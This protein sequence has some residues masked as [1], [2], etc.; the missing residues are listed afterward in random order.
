MET[1]RDKL[2]RLGIERFWA[3]D[4]NADGTR[5][6]AYY[7]D[8]EGDGLAVIWPTDSHEGKRAKDRSSAM[9]YTTRRT[10]PAY[11]FGHYGGG[12]YSRTYELQ[13]DLG[14]WLGRKVRVEMLRGYSPSHA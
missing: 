10:L 14:Q 4:L 5:F 7:I 1:Q 9:T 3:I 13:T 8:P 11:H 12:G 2:N 6:A